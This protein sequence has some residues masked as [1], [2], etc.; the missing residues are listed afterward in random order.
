MPAWLVIARSARRNSSPAG[1]TPASPWMGSSI[2]AAVR[3]VIAAL[4][5]SISPSGTFT[6]PG[7]FGSKSVSQAALPDAAM[8]ARVRPWKP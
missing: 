5:A 4:T 2:T 1:Y 8:V 6:K 7:T 3:G